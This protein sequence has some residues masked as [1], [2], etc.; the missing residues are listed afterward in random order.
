MPGPNTLT[1]P[2][3]LL[4]IAIEL[5]QNGQV[6]QARTAYLKAINIDLLQTDALHFLGVLEYQNGDLL[7]AAE[8]IEK[9]LAKN[10]K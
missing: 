1:E 10:S 9:S 3:D 5:H 4:Q 7:L 6:E 8:Y 2:K